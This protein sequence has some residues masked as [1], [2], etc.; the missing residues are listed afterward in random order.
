MKH[1]TIGAV[2]VV[3]ALALAAAVAMRTD[4]RSG[5]DG[6]AAAPGKEPMAMPCDSERLAALTPLQR[7][8][9]TRKGT[10]PAWS[11][12]YH[13]HHETGAYVCAACGSELFASG[14]KFDSGTGWPSFM[15]PA[16]N[17]AVR[18][19]EDR[20]HGMVRTEAI[21]ARCGGHLGH[22]FPDGPEPTGLRYCIN[23]AAL[24]FQKEGL[25]PSPAAA[26][27]ADRPKEEL[28]T[29]AAGCFW[30]VEAVMERLPGVLDVTSGYTGGSVPSP[31]YEQVSAGRTGHAEAIRVRFDPA[32]VSFET[33]LET[34]WSMHDPTT[35]N[36]Q[37]ADVGSQYRSAIFYHGE[38][39]RLA[40]EASK[41]ALT[42]GKAYPD[43][44][45]TEI[46]PAA[47]FYPAEKYHQD[48][49]NRNTQ[50][51]YC[52]AV[53]LPKLRKLKLFGR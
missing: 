3:G 41:R 19:A 14:D 9:L 37:G 47:E 39:Q 2:A 7:E 33:L 21:C 15:R 51:P 25:A 40:A 38:P 13:D 6:A 32:A 17:G 23:S 34:F 44:I 20:S 29:F 4:S 52:K 5:A 27:A 46:V 22:V 48:Y 42:N 10:E 35:P 43:P 11:G 28:A 53:I 18:E 26:A 24:D 30:C 8:V 49:F 12:K 1:R 31:T 16:V 36:R 50:A 45:M